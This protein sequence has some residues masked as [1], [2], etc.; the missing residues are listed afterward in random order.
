MQAKSTDGFMILAG[1]RG[2][3]TEGNGLVDKMDFCGLVFEKSF[4]P[5]CI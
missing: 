3:V 1:P 4:F 2:S 5:G